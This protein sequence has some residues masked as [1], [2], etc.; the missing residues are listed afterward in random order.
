MIK[1]G[2]IKCKLH[3]VYLRPNIDLHLLIQQKE[4]LI[5]ANADMPELYRCI[6]KLLL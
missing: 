4:K 1:L 6:A 5:Q 3:R 2:M